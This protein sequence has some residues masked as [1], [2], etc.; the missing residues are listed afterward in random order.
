MKL[1]QSTSISR[2]KVFLALIA[3]FAVAATITFGA[4]RVLGRS[5]DTQPS[6][7]ALKDA[8][9]ASVAAIPRLPQ[10][11]EDKLAA[12]LYPELP[13][14]ASVTDP[15]VDRAG[16][17]HSAANL[18][19]SSQNNA[20]LIN[21]AGP[22]V[23]SLPDRNA[24]L[25]QWQQSLRAAVKAGVALPPMTN[26][27]LISELAPTGKFE[28]GG[29]EGVWLYLESERRTIAA[30]MG[31]KF[32]DGMLVGVDFGRRAIPHR[33][34]DIPN[35]FRGSARKT[36]PTAV[37]PTVDN[38]PSQQ[39]PIVRPAKPVSLIH[40]AESN[41]A[42]CAPGSDRGRLCRSAGSRPRSLYAT[43]SRAANSRRFPKTTAAS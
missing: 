19:A 2:L 6:D 9:E 37:P 18:R 28:M 3:A 20:G 34:S 22:L 10:D 11:T 5:L 30:N 17:N 24:R 39:Q 38:N 40:G 7:A 21:T 13:P 23:P 27:Y 4:R 25:S 8:R 12:A 41:S 26:A 35:S 14:L 33:R 31:T 42:S 15:F 1:N 36:S 43:C 32:Y 16:L 29:H